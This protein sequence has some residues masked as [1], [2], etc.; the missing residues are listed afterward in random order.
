MP[1]P[2]PLLSVSKGWLGPCMH[3]PV[4][5]SSVLTLHAHSRIQGRKLCGVGVTGPDFMI[6]CVIPSESLSCL[7]QV[8]EIVY[9]T[10]RQ[11]SP[12]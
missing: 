5:L 9:E 8:V 12:K 4:S 1:D 10:C 7:L 11:K 3:V 2:R 6:H